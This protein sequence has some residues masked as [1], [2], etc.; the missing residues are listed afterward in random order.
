MREQAAEQAKERDAR[1]RR[2]QAHNAELF[3][4]E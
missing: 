1:Q 3:A 2:Y 4:D